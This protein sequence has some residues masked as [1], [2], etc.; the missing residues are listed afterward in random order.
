MRVS[1]TN[2]C[3]ECEV[4]GTGF[5]T[6]KIKMPTKKKIT[7]KRT[8]KKKTTRG[9]G[10]QY[11][12]AKNGLPGKLNGYYQV[13]FRT[14]DKNVIEALYEAAEEDYRSPSNLLAKIVKDYLKSKGRI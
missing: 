1:S 14:E 13:Y 3:L 7:K 8:T 12:P 9:N 5:L 6:R 10:P 11:I 4:G 2:V